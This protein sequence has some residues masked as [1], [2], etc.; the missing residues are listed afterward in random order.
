MPLITAAPA[1]C[2]EHEPIKL[3]FR[4]LIFEFGA[5]VFHANAALSGGLSDW[6]FQN[7]PDSLRSAT[8]FYS[9]N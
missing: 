9:Q 2:F 1:Q 3:P 5:Q 4:D 7:R 8:I 6:A